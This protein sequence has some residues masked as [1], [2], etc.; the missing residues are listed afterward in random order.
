VIRQLDH[1][2]YVSADLDATVASYRERGFTVTPGGEHANGLSYNALIGFSDGS[3]LELVGFHDLEK[4]RGQHSWA[5]V[6]GQGG[7]WADFALLSDDLAGDVA[8][9]G[10]LVVRPPEE[11]GRVRPDGERVWW[12]VAGLEKPL[13]SL[14]EDVTPRDLRVPGGAAA[15]HRNGTAGIARVLVGATDPTIVGKKYEAL[16][17]RGAPAVELRKAERDGLMLVLFS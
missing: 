11:G 16:R 2:V 12:K 1:V 13:P 15:R 14:I 10:P 17:A 9:L 4:A 7:G 6:A 3:Y 8:V 5:P